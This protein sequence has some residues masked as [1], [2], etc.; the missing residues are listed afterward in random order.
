MYKLDSEG[1]RLQEVAALRL[2]LTIR[3]FD[4]C[5]HGKK[6]LAHKLHSLP[7]SRIETEAGT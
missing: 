6:T 3:G 5:L 2:R 1:F 7:P 4:A